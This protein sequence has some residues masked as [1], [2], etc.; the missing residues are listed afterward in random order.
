MA[1]PWEKYQKPDA[2]RDTAP[3]AGPWSRYAPA[4][5]A[6]STFVAQEPPPGVV[7]HGGDGRSYVADKP[8]IGVQRDAAPGSRDEAVQMQALQ[9]RGRTDG[10]LS[11]VARAARP[12]TQGQSLN[13][14]DEFVSTVLAAIEGVQGNSPR[15]AFDFGQEFQRQELDRRREEAPLTSVASEVAGGI[16]TGVAA[17][18]RIFASG[19][20]LGTNIVRG[21]VSG[22][23]GG[24]ASGFGGG[25]GLADRGSDALLGAGIGAGVGVA[26]PLAGAAVGSGV[27]AYGARRAAQEA[28]QPVGIGRR[29]GDQIERE[30]SRDAM[31][32]GDARTRVGAMG[33]DAML[34]DAGQNIGE[35]AEAVA[36]LPGT[37]NKTI[38][39]RLG[40][41]GEA[42]PE[43]I[44][45]AADEALGPARNIAETTD[46]LITQRTAASEP[47]YAA[48]LGRPIEWNDRLQAFVD[49]PVIRKGLREGVEI[50]RLDSLARGE[51]FDPFDLAISG[52]DEAGDPILAGVPNMRTLNVAKKGLD[53]V[54]EGY[55]DPVTGRLN[56]DE[57]GRAIADVQRAFVSELDAANPDYAAARAA[58][59]GP[60]RVRDATGLGQDVFNRSVRPDQLRQRLAAMS[61]DEREAFQIGA[62]DQLAEVMGT[63][64]RDAAAARA[65]FETGWNREKLGLVLGDD[66]RARQFLDTLGT[67]TDFANRANAITGNSAS[68]RR[69]QRAGEYDGQRGAARGVVDPSS[70]LWGDVKR[71]GARAVDAFLDGRSARNAEQMR[72]EF[73]DAVSR[74]G[75]E[76]D[77]LIDATMN[78]GERKTQAAATAD[79]YEEVIRAILGGGALATVGQATR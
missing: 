70:G 28:L 36:N 65:M 26:A 31:T 57:R 72:G 69:L 54:L 7:V 61:D 74:Q 8:E 44:T 21:S 76:R 55:R 30:L 53:N 6:A 25:S 33:P 58:W 43:R 23:A 46:A 15:D 2:T 12:F 79:P 68:A 42:A 32:A 48:A 5:P 10:A 51:R 22:T 40:A 19:A 14:G 18:P 67:E 64:R 39:D 27:R 17:A 29:A 77:A 59:A 34:L 50:H 11:D 52:M 24:A 37:G 73:G 35:G 45:T 75:A 66:D 56:L 62:R 78:Y 41:R 60:T 9:A 20:G 13:F 3:S 49:D 38:R 16:A 4:A 47:A 71:T 1:G 63:A